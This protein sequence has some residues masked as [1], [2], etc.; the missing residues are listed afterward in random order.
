MNS[1]DKEILAGLEEFIRDRRAGKRMTRRN[2][3]RIDNDILI[4]KIRPNPRVLRRV[5]DDLRTLILSIK[6]YGVLNHIMVKK[7]PRTYRLIAGHRRVLACKKLGMETIPA[8]VIDTRNW[9]Y[10]RILE[11]WEGRMD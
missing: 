6:E 5:D 7:T 3:W 11:I 10:N 2:F 1:I 4:S 9:A 8:M